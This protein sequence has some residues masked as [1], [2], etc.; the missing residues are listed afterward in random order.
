MHPHCAQLLA[1]TLHEA[2]HDN[3]AI[4]ILLLVIAIVILIVI[5]TRRAALKKPL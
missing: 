5:D 1:M 2:C 4:I 3:K